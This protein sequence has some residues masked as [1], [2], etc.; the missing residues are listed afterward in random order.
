MAKQ[1]YVW[2]T[3]SP[4][5]AL[6]FLSDNGPKLLE[7]RVGR[8]RICLAHDQEEVRAFDAKCPHSGGPLAG[9]F[10]EEGLVV[11]PWHRMKFDMQTGDCPKGGYYINAYPVKV[12][13][14]RIEVGIPKR[15][16]FWGIF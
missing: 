11:C 5:D 8:K 16:K 7:T 15:K 12:T 13:G 10:I 9:G 2:H 1:E 3:V 6:R 14:Q 4:M